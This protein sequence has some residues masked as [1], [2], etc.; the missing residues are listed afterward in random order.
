[1]GMI[2][3]RSTIAPKRATAESVTREK[4]LAAARLFWLDLNARLGQA[5]RHGV[6]LEEATRRLEAREAL[7]AKRRSRRPSAKKR[8]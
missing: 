8:R 1:M 5:R 7:D 2:R 4:K 6:S 3:R